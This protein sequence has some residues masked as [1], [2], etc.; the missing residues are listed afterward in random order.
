MMRPR[1]AFTLIELL[2]AIVLGSAVL[3]LLSAT[4]SRVLTG[5]RA[6]QDHLQG[7][8]SLGRLAEQFRDDVHAAASAGSDALGNEPA[9]LILEQGDGISVAYA[10]DPDGLARIETASGAVRRRELFA[11]SGMKVLGW[12]NDSASTRRVSLEVAR[13]AGEHDEVVK[14]RLSIEALLGADRALRGQP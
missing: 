3:G 11:L 14:T 6:A 12:T 1:A 7:A 9:R 13:L 4:M 2:V 8:N 5:S 10:I